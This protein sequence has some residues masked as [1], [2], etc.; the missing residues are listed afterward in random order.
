MIEITTILVIEQVV[1]VTL[2]AIGV[3]VAYAVFA[4][5]VATCLRGI[6]KNYPEVE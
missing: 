5:A 1:I 6:S 3:A 4:L 2:I